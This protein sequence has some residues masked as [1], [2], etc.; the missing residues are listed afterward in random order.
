MKN[1]I[2]WG[3]GRLASHL[4]LL[5][6]EENISYE[7]IGKGRLPSKTAQCVIDF[8]HPGALEDLLSYCAKYQ[9]PLLIATTGHSAQQIELIELFSRQIPLCCDSNFSLGVLALKKAV[10]ALN[11][12]LSGW[13]TEI[14]EAHRKAKADAPSGTALSLS[15]LFDA[16]PPIHSVRAGD[17][18][19]EHTLIYASR[20]EKMT[21]THEAFT[22]IIFAKGALFCAKK[23]I[24]MP[25]GLYSAQDLFEVK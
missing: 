12:L 6:E 21:L 19:G 10:K 11:S 1:I 22:P 13:D 3:K 24:N 16:P 23:L 17:L 20:G 5:C 9:T 2:I 4:A 14:V 7:T 8:S 18:A 25:N 15:R